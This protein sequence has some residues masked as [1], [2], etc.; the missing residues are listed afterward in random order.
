MTKPNTEKKAPVPKRTAAPKVKTLRDGL[1]EVFAEKGI[2]PSMP[3]AD[4]TAAWIVDLV[5]R[6]TGTGHDPLIVARYVLNTLS[7]HGLMARMTEIKERFQAPDLP[8]MAVQA[9]EAAYIKALKTLGNAMDRA[10]LLPATL[11][12]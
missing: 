11:D 7:R 9:E 6:A 10:P 4:F 3:F 12:P 8:D 5:P 2:D 1:M